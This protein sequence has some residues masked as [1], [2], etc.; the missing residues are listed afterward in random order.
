MRVERVSPRRARASKN[1]P[2]EF[3]ERRLSPKLADHGEVGPRGVG[4]NGA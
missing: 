1:D 2:A 4:E 3:V